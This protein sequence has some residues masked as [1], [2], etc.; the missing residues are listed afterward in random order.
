MLQLGNEKTKGVFR[1]R[2]VPPIWSSDEDKKN[3]TIKGTVHES[4]YSNDDIYRITG[5]KLFNNK[6]HLEWLAHRVRMNNSCLVYIKYDKL[7]WRQL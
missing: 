3:V 1:L 6:K 5:T 7:F 4:I 2:N